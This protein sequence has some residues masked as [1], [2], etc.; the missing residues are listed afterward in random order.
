MRAF[1]ILLHLF[2]MLGAVPGGSFSSWASEWKFDQI[3]LKNGHRFDGLL[4]AENQQQIQFKYVIRNPG[5][6]TLVIETSFDKDEVEQLIALS[7]EERRELARRLAQLDRNGERE[8]ERMASVTVI[9]HPWEFSP[10]DEGRTYR[11]KYFEITSNVDAAFFRQIVVRLEDIFQAYVD[12]LGARLQ[13]KTPVKVLLFSQMDDYQAWMRKQRLN[14]LNPA[15]Y[16]SRKN[17][18]VAGSDLDRLQQELKVV[19][20][21][22]QEKLKHIQEY[23]QR[24]MNH[25]SGRPP[26][27][28]LQQVKELQ[29]QIRLTSQENEATLD[30]LREQFFAMLYHEAFHA[31]LDH[32]VY[33]HREMSTPRWLNE[34]LA[35]IFESAV[36]ETGELR[37]GHVDPLRL[38]AVQAALKEQ[39]LLSLRDLLQANAASFNVSHTAETLA[40]D[41]T[42][43]A[44]WALAFYLTFDRKLLGKEPMHQFVLMAGSAKDQAALFERMIDQP[45]P[46]FEKQFRDYW[47][48]LRPDGTLKTAVPGL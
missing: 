27:H 12:N 40:A 25:Y 30:K 37:V 35:Q 46:E 5:M 2:L 23:H 7:A 39:S 47:L 36:V 42:Y 22:H 16:D 34:G 3:K 31:Y 33:P 32:Y 41:R 1:P 20:A 14:F 28:L 10:K 19:D 18:M 21:K 8:K 11:G 17:L 9:L 26:A 15:F 6:K 48:R 45:L 38:A 44:S 29:L 13:P 4:V 43:L 24:L